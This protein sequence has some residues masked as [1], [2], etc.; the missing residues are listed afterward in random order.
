MKK[1]RLTLVI[2]LALVSIIGFVSHAAADDVS[3]GCAVLN[4]PMFDG[5][6]HAAF[7]LG[8]LQFRAGDTLVI[9]AGP[10]HIVPLPGSRPPSRRGSPDITLAIKGSVVDTDTVPGQL[11][12]AF[13]SDTLVPDP[14]VGWANSDGVLLDWDVTCKH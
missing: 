7:T 5:T 2:I 3:K 4:D 9:T 1:Q 6:Y 14:A 11:V 8:S 10:P 12:Y 13:A